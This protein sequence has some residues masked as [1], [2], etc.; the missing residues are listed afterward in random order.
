MPV[1]PFSGYVTVTYF[2][3]LFTIMKVYS[4]LSPLAGQTDEFVLV[5]QYHFICPER[6][7]DVLVTENRT[8]FLLFFFILFFPRFFYRVSTAYV[9]LDKRFLSHFCFI[10]KVAIF[11]FSALLSL[12]VVI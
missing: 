5:Y 11:H 3:K 8:C 4:E 10:T 2:S 12:L 1:I 6:S 9:F 7:R